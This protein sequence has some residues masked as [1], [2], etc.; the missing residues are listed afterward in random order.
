IAM[1][2]CALCLFVI[3]GTETKSNSKNESA[4]NNDS[5]QQQLLE[6]SQKYL[7]SIRQQS[8]NLSPELQAKLKLQ[9]QNAVNKGLAKLNCPAKLVQKQTAPA[10]LTVVSNAVQKIGKTSAFNV[11]EF[12]CRD[13]HQVTELEVA[14]RV[15]LPT[16]D[17]RQ[18]GRFLANNSSNLFGWFGRDLANSTA[19]TVPASPRNGKNFTQI[20][21][22]LVSV[23]SIKTESFSSYCSANDNILSGFIL[24]AQTVIQRK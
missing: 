12:L 9:A 10:D 14:V 11:A 21:G 16:W 24:I 6:R 7:D 23:L 15:A 3:M 19:I 20:L 4:D 2:F 5:F 1:M 13:F 17:F 18:Y 22:Q 8:T